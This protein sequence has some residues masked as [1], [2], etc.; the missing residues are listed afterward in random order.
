LSGETKTLEFRKKTL[1]R[2]LEG[3]IS[4]EGEFNEALKKDLGHNEFIC[5]FGAHS[6]TKA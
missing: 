4:L 5:N 1:K 6:L 3:Y 2:L